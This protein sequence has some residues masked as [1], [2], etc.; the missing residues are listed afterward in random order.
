MFPIVQTSSGASAYDRGHLYGRAA[1][2]RVAQSL[3]TYARLFAF[4]GIAWRDARAL[5]MR[6]LPVIDALDGSLVSELQGIADGSGQPFDAILALNCRTEILP[7]S[8]LNGEPHAAGAALAANAAEGLEDWSECT[9]MCVAAS[10]SADGNA[11]FAQNWDWLGRQRAA[12]VLLKTVDA[13][14]MGLTTLTEAG[15]LA[16]IGMNDAG[17]CLGLNIV[18]SLGDGAV[19]GL[20]VHVL[21]RHLLSCRSVAHARERLAMLQPLGFGAASNIPCADAEG[22]AACFEVAPAGWAELRPVNGVVVHTNHFQCETLQPHQAPMGAFV[23]SEPRLATAEQHAV[24]GPIGFEALQAFLRDD[25]G[26]L[27]GICRGPNPEWPAEGRIESVAGIIMHPA[28]RSI[29]IAPDVP[30]R[31]DFSRV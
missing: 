1:A 31:V 16:K 12:L 9:A 28:T 30:N 7:S 2:A 26:G 20:P 5:A 19:P 25:S 11:W 23:S 14:G 27:L 29:W 24:R 8:Y 10:A 22:E 21:L 18:R 4:C 15:M 13:A 17:F 6:Y 3:A